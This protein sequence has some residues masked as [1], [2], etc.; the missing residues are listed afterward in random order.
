MIWPILGQSAPP[1]RKSFNKNIFS[2]TYY[3]DITGV[4]N[5]IMETTVNLIIETLNIY[6]VDSIKLYLQYL[7]FQGQFELE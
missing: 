2:L 1:G 3:K 5:L 4:Q 7:L 6:K